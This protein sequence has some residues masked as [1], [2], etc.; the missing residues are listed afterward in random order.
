MGLCLSPILIIKKKNKYN[1]K[2]KYQT[3]NYNLLVFSPNCEFIFLSD[4]I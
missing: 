4:K 3:Y 2:T 1:I